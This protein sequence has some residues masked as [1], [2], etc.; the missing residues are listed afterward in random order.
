MKRHISSRARIGLRGG[1]RVGVSTVSTTVAR[2]FNGDAR[3]NSQVKVLV[4]HQ[5]AALVDRICMILT[6]GYLLRS[7]A[8]RVLLRTKTTTCVRRVR[9]SSSNT[10]GQNSHQIPRQRVTARRRVTLVSD[11]LM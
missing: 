7:I 11:V 9:M 3:S 5:A 8:S 2:F 1:E 6:R 10:M 4:D